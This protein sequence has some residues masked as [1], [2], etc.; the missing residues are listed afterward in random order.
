MDDFIMRERKEEEARLLRAR[1]R[2]A[3]LWLGSTW[4]DNLKTKTLENFDV[5]RQSEAVDAIHI[6]LR[7][8]TGTLVLYGPFGVGKTHLLAALCNQLVHK[9]E[10]PHF[11]TS[12]NLFTAIQYR[13]RNNQDYN[14]ILVSASTC[15]LLILDDI[16]KAKWSEF[17]E[18]IY[19]AIIDT[20][21]NR[22][23]PTAI[24]TNRLTELASFVGGAVASRLS[25]GQLAVAMKGEDYRP[26]V[27]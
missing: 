3:Y 8:L 23:L 12:P 2:S 10:T 24:S 4:G 7:D 19:F 15:N 14:D 16:D 25:V 6:F 1:F 18:E 5:S 11:A 20:R 27:K 26:L 17:R 22:G 13:V 9:G 21:V